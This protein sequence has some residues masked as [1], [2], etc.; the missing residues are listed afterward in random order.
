MFDPLERKERQM[1]N[2]IIWKNRLF[3]FTQVGFRRGSY[4]C[5]YCTNTSFHYEFLAAILTIKHIQMKAGIDRNNGRKKV[6]ETKRE[7]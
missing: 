1:E 4:Q 3:S 6:I 5:Y 2:L 7:N